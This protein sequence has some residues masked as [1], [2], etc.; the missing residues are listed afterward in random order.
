M[1]LV[2]GKTLAGLASLLIIDASGLIRCEAARVW[3]FLQPL[4]IVPAGLT[5]AGFKPSERGIILGVSA[6][7]LIAIVCKLIFLRVP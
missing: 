1:G 7:I 3:L 6:L 5:L 2:P 4:A